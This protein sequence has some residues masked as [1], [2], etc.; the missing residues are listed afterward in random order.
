MLLAIRLADI[1]EQVIEEAKQSA[2]Q[3]RTWRGCLVDEHGT[4]IHLTYLMDNGMLLDI[5]LAVRITNL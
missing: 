5:T 4:S 2:A 1:V 3:R